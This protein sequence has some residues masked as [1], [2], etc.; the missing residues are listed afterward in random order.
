[1]TLLNSYLVAR[2]VLTLISA[3][4]RRN[5]TAV[6][7]PR[8]VEQVL[9]RPHPRHHHCA[10]QPSRKRPPPQGL[11]GSNFP[12]ARGRRA[13][14]LLKRELAL[15]RLGSLLGIH[16]EC[17]RRR[18]QRLQARLPAPS[19]RSRYGNSSQLFGRT[20]STS[21]VRPFPSS[22]FGHNTLAT[23]I[24]EYFNN[25]QMTPCSSSM[26][27]MAWVLGSIVRQFPSVLRKP[28]D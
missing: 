19:A 15:L 26:Q 5:F 17:L 21:N 16:S 28:L 8:G 18:R 14:A 27:L 9:V 25:Q 12:F 13:N 1:M 4:D 10:C 22:L 11:T 3:F 23:F 2:G 6:D 7:F 20:Q 24:C